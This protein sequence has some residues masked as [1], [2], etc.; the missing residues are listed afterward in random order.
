MEYTHNLIVMSM[1]ALELYFV[2]F[3][4]SLYSIIV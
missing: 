2:D 4:Y 3:L 1:L